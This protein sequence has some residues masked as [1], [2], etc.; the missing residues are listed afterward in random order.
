MLVPVPV[1]VPDACA[2]LAAADDAV[3]RKQKW[4]PAA[5][6]TW[7]WLGALLPARD[8]ARPLQWANISNLLD[9]STADMAILLPPFLIHDI[10]D[11]FSSFDY[12]FFLQIFI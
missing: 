4:L 7:V 3:V 12:S 1:P 6:G 2:L 8:T 10:I 5:L 9:H 11:F